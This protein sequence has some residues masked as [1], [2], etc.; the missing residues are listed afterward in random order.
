MTDPDGIPISDHTLVRERAIEDYKIKLSLDKD[1]TLEDYKATL[2][3]GLEQ[4]RTYTQLFISRLNAA[5]NYALSALR[6]ILLLNGGAIITIFTYLGNFER[7]RP[8]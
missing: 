2:T 7:V 6:G 1:R 5:S 3:L 4:Q 8:G